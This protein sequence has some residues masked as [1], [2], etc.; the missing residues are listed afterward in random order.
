MLI[1][2]STEGSRNG[3]PSSRVYIGFGLSNDVS[4]PQVRE[5]RKNNDQYLRSTL[6]SMTA[7]IYTT[8]R[9]EYLFASL[10]GVH[11]FDIFIA[12]VE[13]SRAFSSSIVHDQTAYTKEKGT[14]TKKKVA[15]K[16]RCV[17]NGSWINDRET[18]ICSLCL[19]TI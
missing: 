17:T 5:N 6:V 14:I 7:G 2:R 18:S 12:L 8:Y 1:N 16:R 4:F 10:S 11:P 15:G 19:K 9:L 3:H 13:L